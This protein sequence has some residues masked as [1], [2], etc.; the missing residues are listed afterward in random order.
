MKFDELS[1]EL[2]EK[3]KACKTNE[4]LAAILKTE[5]IELAEE[6]LEVLSGGHKHMCYSLDDCGLYV[7]DD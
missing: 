3:I 6:Q 7:W 1:P 4:E 2:E 5:G